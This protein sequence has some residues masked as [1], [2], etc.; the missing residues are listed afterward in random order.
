MASVVIVETVLNVLPFSAV[1]STSS[2]SLGFI[3][4]IIVILS[5]NEVLFV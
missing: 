2:L 3:Q 5:V 1:G 4:T